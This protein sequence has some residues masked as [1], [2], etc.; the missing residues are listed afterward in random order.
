MTVFNLITRKGV[1]HGLKENFPS[2]WSMLRLKYVPLLWKLHLWD[3]VYARASR[4]FGSEAMRQ[5]FTFQTM[6]L[7]MSPF[8]APA[9][10]N[11]LQY[12]EMAEGIWY[13][14]GGFNAVVASLEAIAKKHGAQFHYGTPVE[15]IV[16]SERKEVTGLRLENG[17]TVE[18]DIVVCNADLVYGY[19]KLLPETR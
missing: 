10:F 1:A 5:A 14:R 18:A 6:Y 19:N 7:G 11:L 8:D 9:L 17:E 2:F 3:T 15:R 13:P 16:V 4:F 12:T